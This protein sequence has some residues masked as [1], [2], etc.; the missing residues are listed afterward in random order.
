MRHVASAQFNT[1]ITASDDRNFVLGTF[2]VFGLNRS[3]GAPRLDI[4]AALFCCTARFCKYDE[5][6]KHSSVTAS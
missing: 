5:Q 4:A 2:S 3:L 1:V 6:G